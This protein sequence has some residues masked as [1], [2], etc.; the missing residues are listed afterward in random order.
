[1]FNPLNTVWNMTLAPLC[2]INNKKGVAQATPFFQTADSRFNLRSDQEPAFK[3]RI[4][5]SNGGC[6]VNSALIP[7]PT[8]EE[9]P[10]ATS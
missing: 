10:K 8:L 3:A 9:I 4:R 2:S 5:S 7:R 6:D 1:M